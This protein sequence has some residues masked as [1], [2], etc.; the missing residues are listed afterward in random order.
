M[1]TH[2]TVDLPQV[3]RDAGLPVVSVTWTVLPV[4]DE[5]PMGRI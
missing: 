4:S 2:V 5:C 1:Y 3:I